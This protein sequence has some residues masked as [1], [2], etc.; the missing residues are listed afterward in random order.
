[1]PELS[2]APLPSSSAARGTHPPG[3]RRASSR[4]YRI[5]SP[6]SRQQTGF[7]S[8]SNV[9]PRSSGCTSRQVSAKSGS[10]S[11]RTQ[12]SSSPGPS[13]GSGRRQSPHVFSSSKLKSPQRTAP[14]YSRRHREAS[15]SCWRRQGALLSDS[16]CVV[17]TTRPG[18]LPPQ[19]THSRARPMREGSGRAPNVGSR[20]WRMRGGPVD[21]RQ[22]LAAA[23]G[24][25]EGR[26]DLLE[27]RHVGRGGQHLPEQSRLAL[28]GADGVEPHVP[29]HHS[30]ARRGPCG[31]SPRGRDRLLIEEQSR[32]RHV[33]ADRRH[34][35]MH[36][37]EG[38][39]QPARKTG[40]MA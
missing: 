40:A 21:R 19:R 14:S 28:R 26:H 27:A 15:S 29:G 34:Q 2:M 31:Q 39:Q 17:A 3:P 18:H 37:P 12:F 7:S 4:S 5:R 35:Q 10:S 16:R 25:G 6:R 9:Y 8:P 30:Q 22:G 23:H 32:P 1:M 20:S 38:R 24:L 11:P 13:A 36:A 33:A